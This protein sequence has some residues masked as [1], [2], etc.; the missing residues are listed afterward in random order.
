[1]NPTIDSDAIRQCILTLLDARRAEA[2]ICPSEVARALWPGNWRDHM[3]E[4]RDI[5]AKM[6][7][8]HQLIVTQ[9][10][11]CVDIRNAHGPVRLRKP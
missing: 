8:E 5:A 7:D 10:G 4:V 9:K 11:H 3:R 2:S 1:M 6:Q